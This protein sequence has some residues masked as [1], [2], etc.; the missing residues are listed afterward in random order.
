MA[1]LLLFML[2]E[3]LNHC[4]Q[5]Y[6]QRKKKNRCCLDEVSFSSNL[7]SLSFAI[8]EIAVNLVNLMKH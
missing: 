1:L 5:Y 6:C 7:F 8:I 3:V 4:W 2:S